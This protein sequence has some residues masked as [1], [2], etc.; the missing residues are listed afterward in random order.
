MSSTMLEG[1][2]MF[3]K[4][5]SV[6][7]IFRIVEVETT[8]YCNRKC[9][10][11]PNSLYNRGNHLMEWSTYKKLIDD[12]RE[13]SF[14]GMISP[15]FYGEPM[16]DD[17]LIDIVKYTKGQLPQ[18]AIRITTNGDYLTH[19]LLSG[20]LNAGVDQFYITTYDDSATAK[21]NSLIVSLDS[22]YTSRFE[23]RTIDKIYM[24]NR[25][26]LLN[27]QTSSIECCNYPSEYL[28][29]DYRGNILLCCND[30]T[31]KY[32]FGSIIEEKVMNIWNRQE[33]N[34]VRTELL[35]GIFNN[36]I[37]QKCTGN[38]QKNSTG[39]FRER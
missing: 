21:I 2:G 12:L 20:L 29:I 22:E 38:T 9:T 36:E 15:H 33:F 26:G 39:L 18:V 14:K 32:I 8:T 34:H 30:Y 24:L 19:D 31:A 5:F 7:K 3:M 1:H 27:I 10:F 11:C 16:S 25:G 35:H 17:R 37:C 13:M 28:V 4:T 6:D 23:H